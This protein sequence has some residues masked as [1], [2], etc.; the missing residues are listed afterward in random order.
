MANGFSSQYETDF[1]DWA[2]ST[3]ALI[4]RGELAALDFD[5]LAEEVES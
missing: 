3:D 4:R 1:Y 2:M 5:A